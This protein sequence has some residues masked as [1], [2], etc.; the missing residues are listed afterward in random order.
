M[1]HKGDNFFC[2]V[3]NFR[4]WET[5]TFIWY[6]YHYVFNTIS[7]DNRVKS[8]SPVRLFETPWIVAYQTPPSMG[9]SRQEYWS[10]FPFSSPWDLPNPGMEPRSSTLREDA[11]TS[12]PQGKPWWRT[13]KK[14]KTHSMF[15]MLHASKG[16]GEAQKEQKKCWGIVCLHTHTKK[17]VSNMIGNVVWGHIWRILRTIPTMSGLHILAWGRGQSG[18]SRYFN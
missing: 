12:E 4:P 8:L 11:L 3:N 16:K 10:G 18:T 1:A 5:L 13:E 2:L 17:I 14:F 6:L 9:F 15:T 7:R